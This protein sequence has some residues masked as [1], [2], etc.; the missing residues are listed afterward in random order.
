MWGSCLQPVRA[1]ACCFWPL[2]APAACRPAPHGATRQ[3]STQQLQFAWTCDVCCLPL[4]S[5]ILCMPPQ[6]PQFP[7]R[8]PRRLFERQRRVWGQQPLR[9]REH[10]SGWPLRGLR[11]GEAAH[12]GPAA[13][14]TAVGGEQPRRR[15]RS[16]SIGSGCSWTLPCIAP[17][18]V[19]PA[20][21]PLV[22]GVGQTPTP[23]RL[24]LTR[25]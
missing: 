4:Q 22:P 18:P 23:C 21:M 2:T 19:V 3:T 14:G 10:W 11:V 9:T 7:R 12:P 8:R 16:P 6:L 15:Q 13:P 1:C 17:C 24:T 25:T 20:L 5:G